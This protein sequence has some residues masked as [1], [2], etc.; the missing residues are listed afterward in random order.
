M[1]REAV[2]KYRNTIENHYNVVSASG[3]EVYGVT[4]LQKWEGHRLYLHIYFD[5]DKAAG[6]KKAF[7]HKL[8]TTYEALCNGANI[9]DEKF[10]EKYFTIKETKIRGR[11]VFYNDEAIESH[12]K[13]RVGWFVMASNF[14]KDKTEALAIY[15]EKD[16]VGKSFDD[17]KNQMDMKRLRVHSE[18]TMNGRIFVQFLTLIIAVWIRQK[19]LEVKWANKYSYQEIMNEIGELKKVSESGKR[20]NLTLQTISLQNQIIELFGL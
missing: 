14:I 9:K 16:C 18:E 17:L 3:N 8:H 20:K 13:N 4:E 5:S 2:E 11:K 12:L 10:V 7:N 6:E 1:A 15:R 19:L